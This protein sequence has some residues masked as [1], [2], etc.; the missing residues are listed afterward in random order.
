MK[1]KANFTLVLAGLLMV[2]GCKGY[3]LLYP[4]RGPLASMTPVPSYTFNISYPGAPKNDRD[5]SGELSMV[6]A[7]GESFSGPWKMPYVK[8]G[9]QVSGAT[10]TAGEG[11]A[12]A[13]D[14]VY[15]QGFYVAHVLGAD[16]VARSAL[17]G[18]Q[19]TVLQIE[20]WDPGPAGTTVV[21]SKGVAT[22]SKGNIYKL[23][24]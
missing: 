1:S 19:G 18:S 7:N 23:G 10:T 20:W 8:P 3:G 15:G 5:Q 21:G 13:W 4:V 2:C 6:L 14:A 9:K 16:R 17:K 22:D 24:W 11:M 12:E